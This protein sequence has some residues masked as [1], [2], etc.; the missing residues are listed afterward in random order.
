M[1]VESGFFCVEFIVATLHTAFSSIPLVR[2]L[3]APGAS[4]STRVD[5]ASPLL[6]LL[7]RALRQ[8]S[9]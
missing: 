7:W 3:L 9:E 5:G 8:R 6:E 2:F 1:K 4:G